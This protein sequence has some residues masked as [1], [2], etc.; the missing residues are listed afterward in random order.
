M[1]VAASRAY[2]RLRLVAVRHP[3]TRRLRQLPDSR[4][5]R[6]AIPQD[7][8]ATWRL[9]WSNSRS[10]YTLRNNTPMKLFGKELSCNKK[11]L[12]RD[13]RQ[14]LRGIL[15]ELVHIGIELVKS[16]FAEVFRVLLA[17]FLRWSEPQSR[18]RVRYAGSSPYQAVLAARYIE[19]YPA[20]ARRL[21]KNDRYE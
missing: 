10:T 9:G 16:I 1:P 12:A 18:A 21:A 17:D 6:R 13:A 2:A 3:V 5:R 14:I 4:Y 15:I 20:A 19:R 8:E 11:A 7:T